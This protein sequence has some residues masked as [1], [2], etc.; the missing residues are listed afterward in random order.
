LAKEGRD[1]YFLAPS[2]N[3]EFVHTGATV[4][5]CVLGGGWPLGR[6]SN[7]VGD[8]ST[9]KT[10]VACEAMAN[11]GRKFPKGMI[12]YVE[13]EAAFD[14]AYAVALG[15]PMDRVERPDSQLETVEAVFE[16]LMGALSK[17]KRGGLYILDSLDALSD[18]AE[19][20]R[21]IDKA[22][23][24]AGKAKGMS[25][26]FRRAIKKVEAKHCHFMIISQIRDNIGATFGRKYSR[27]G[28]KALDFYASQV[29]YLAHL[30]ELKRKL[31][32]VER[33]IGVQIR[34]KCTKNKVGLPFRT[35]DFPILFGYGI[36]DIT[37][38]I[39]WLV[40]NKQHKRTGLSLEELKSIREDAM[41]VEV[42]GADD[43]RQLLATNVIAG[44]SEIEKSFL[45]PRRK[46]ND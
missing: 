45:P 18:A 14:D 7:I 39:D 40:M 1:Q 35:C 12:R 9:G 31:K 34:M 42:D 41:K 36:E 17:M 27:S 16:D 46:Y 5:D 21:E 26:L 20:G 2:A 22:T 37:A 44:W 28:G 19:M 11:F 8:K 24:G 29:A 30:G 3:L 23:F 15:I 25:Q 43:I 32:G 4:L 10:L 13:T 38:S 33:T 6:V